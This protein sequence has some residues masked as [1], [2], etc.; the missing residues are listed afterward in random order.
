M[1]DNQLVILFLAANRIKNIMACTNIL[2]YTYSR[3]IGNHSFSIMKH[4]QKF[5]LFLY[6][7]KKEVT[8]YTLS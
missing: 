1:G 8:G 6:K 3:I 5:P 7:K 2:S 4:K